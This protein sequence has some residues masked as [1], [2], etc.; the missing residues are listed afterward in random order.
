MTSFHESITRDEFDLDGPPLDTTKLLSLVGDIFDTEGEGFKVKKGNLHTQH[1]SMSTRYND[2]DSDVDSEIIDKEFNFEII[3]KVGVYIANTEEDFNLEEFLINETDSTDAAKSWE[4][5]GWDG[6]NCDSE[7]K[8][9]SNE[10]QYW[11]DYARVQA[12]SDMNKLNKE[13]DK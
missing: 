7:H 8:R 12:K 6:Y 3:R 4:K 9:A 1:V 11:A 13:S 2:I 5:L 10:D